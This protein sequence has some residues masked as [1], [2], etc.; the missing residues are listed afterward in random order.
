MHSNFRFN[1]MSLL[2][3]L[4]VNRTTFVLIHCGLDTPPWNFQSIIIYIL[5][6]P[7]M[8]GYLHR[9]NERSYRCCGGYMYVVSQHF[10][11]MR[12]G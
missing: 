5:I 4:E 7:A 6:M 9:I 10:L 11:G 2:E 1:E 3:W 12:K 8:P